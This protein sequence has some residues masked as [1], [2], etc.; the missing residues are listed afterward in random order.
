MYKLAEYARQRLL[1]LLGTTPLASP[2]AQWYGA[3]AH[4]PLPPG[5]AQPLQQWLWDQHR[6]EVPI[7]TWHDQRYVRVSCHLY[8][9]THH[10]DRLVEALR[11]HLG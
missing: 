2:A 4:V 6:I 5:E 11:N 9:T 3:M 10:I 1:D 8:N 7:V